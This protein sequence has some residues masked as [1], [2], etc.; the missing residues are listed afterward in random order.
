[1][2]P[3]IEP[4]INHP[5]PTKNS[6][7]QSRAT[8][9]VQQEGL[10]QRND[11][12]EDALEGQLARLVPQVPLG[13]EGGGRATEQRARVQAHLGHV[14]AGDML[15]L[16]LVVHVERERRRVDEQQVEHSAAGPVSVAGQQ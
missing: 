16:R 6:P 3:L 15:R 4:A 9:P 11:G 12:P 13:D 14:P 7:A 5:L 10:L 1:M 8:Q 2:N